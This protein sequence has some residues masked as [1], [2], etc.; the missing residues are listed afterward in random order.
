[1][2]HSFPARSPERAAP[3]IAMAAE[4][5]EQMTLSRVQ[6]LRGAEGALDSVICS[7]QTLAIA[8]DGFL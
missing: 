7:E 1:M 2:R 5:S 3:S 6:P 8:I 4:S